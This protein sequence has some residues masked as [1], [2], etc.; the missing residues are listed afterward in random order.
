MIIFDFLVAAVIVAAQ[1]PCSQQREQTV[2]HLLFSIV[3]LKPFV[4]AI[5]YTL[6]SQTVKESERDGK[7]VAR[8][9]K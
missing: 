1:A 3:Y 7:I 5:Q 8:K 2:P 9:V 6:T 4:S